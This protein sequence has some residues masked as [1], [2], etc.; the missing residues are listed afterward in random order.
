M[1]TRFY[2]LEVAGCKR[3]L[4]ILNVTDKLAIAGFIMLGDTEL[5]EECAKALVE[6]LP[7][8]LD[9]LVCPEAKAI[10]LTHAMARIMGI[11]YIVIRKSVKVYMD[12]PL[13]A[14][15]K[16]ITTAQQQH[17]VMDSADV[18]KLYGKRVA[19]VDDVVSTGGSLHAVEEILSR[20][21]CKVV[22]KVAPLLE[23]G[24]YDGHDVVYLERLPV[25]PD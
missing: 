15:V 18:K 3:K 16:S 21:A 12:N 13:I 4:S 6:K 24:G 14:D 11:D 2:D 19:I 17:L 10:P 7:K 1:A 23:E 9:F 25:F 22:A 20:T 8:D 5:V